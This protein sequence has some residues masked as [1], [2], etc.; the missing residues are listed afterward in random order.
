MRITYEGRELALV[1]WGPPSSQ[2]ALFDAAAR[3]ADKRR[4]KGRTLILSRY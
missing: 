1:R 2:K 4:A 3:R